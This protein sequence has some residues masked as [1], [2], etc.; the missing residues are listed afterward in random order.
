MYG[1]ELSGQNYRKA[2]KS[3][4]ITTFEVETDLTQEMEWNAVT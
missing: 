1:K 3:E 2:F 4:S